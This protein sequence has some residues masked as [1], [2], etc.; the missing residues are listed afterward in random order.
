M[1]RWTL[2]QAHTATTVYGEGSCIS[3]DTM[4][5]QIDGKDIIT[6]AKLL[7]V[8]T[9]DV[10]AYNEEAA[11]GSRWGVIASLGGGS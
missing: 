10:Y 2:V 11:S 4:P 7:A 9:G 6:G 8:D 5:E 3:T 1:V